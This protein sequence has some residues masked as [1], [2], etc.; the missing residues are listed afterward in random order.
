MVEQFDVLSEKMISSLQKSLRLI[1]Q[2]L[3]LGVQEFADLIGVTRQTVNNL[4]TQKSQMNVTQ[5]VAICSVIDYYTANK[6]Q[7]RRI[8]Y[9]FLQIDNDADNVFARVIESTDV[10]LLKRWFA[11]FEDDLEDEVTKTLQGQSDLINADSDDRVFERSIE[12]DFKYLVKN[13]RIFF[14][15]TVLMHPMFESFAEPLLSLIEANGGSVIVPYKVV[16]FIYGYDRNGSKRSEVGSH[17]LAQLN[18]RKILEVRGD[19]NDSNVAATLISVFAKFKSKYKLALF[20]QDE[21]LANQILSLNGNIIGGFDVSVYRLEPDGSF[22]SW[23]SSENL[24][25]VVDI[26]DMDN[27]VSLDNFIS[28]DVIQDDTDRF[29]GWDSI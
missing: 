15:D 8:V 7:L 17:L 26:D 19:K 18:R 16:E 2:S 27:M 9:Q 28:T 21:G 14:D 25:D 13:Y 20:T 12:C 11:L 3:E 1:R 29:C 6:P 24:S 4:E 5:F 22:K 10:P 23:N